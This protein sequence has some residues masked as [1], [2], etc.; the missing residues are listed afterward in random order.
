MN[1]SNLIRWSGLAAIL[2]G[3]LLLASDLL[4]L[5]PISGSFSETAITGSYAVENGLRLLGGMLMLL[6]LVGLYVRQSEASDTP[7]LIGFLV[8]FAGTSLVLG[9]FWVN[10]FVAPSLATEA[11]GFL[12]AG[13]TGALW[14]GFTSSFALAALGWVLFGAATLRACV[15]PR[16]ASALLMI[17]VALT[18]TPAARFRRGLRHGRGLA[19]LR[20]PLEKGSHDPATRAREM[21][22]E[23]HVVT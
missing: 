12:D 13:T 5:I 17:G 10:A 2:G 16:A 20:P 1:S 18:F 19:G 11:P 4:G 9:A 3:A 14:L 21:S 7:K 23:K 22:P 6:G 15:Y 8:A